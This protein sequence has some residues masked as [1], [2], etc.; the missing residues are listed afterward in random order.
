MFVFHSYLFYLLCYMSPLFDFCVLFSSL[1]RLFC[2]VSTLVLCLCPFYLFIL[3][4]LLHV[5]LFHVCV[6]PG[7]LHFSFFSFHLQVMNISQASAAFNPTIYD[8]VMYQ[9]ITSNSLHSW[10]FF[11]WGG[12]MFTLN[13]FCSVLHGQNVILQNRIKIRTVDVSILMLVFLC[14][15]RIIT[16][17]QIMWKLGNYG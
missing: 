17:T 9:V 2:Y 15:L 6:F 4:V 3:F 12:L 7:C 1:F 5:P 13:S 10:R 11:F 8:V 16:T 14:T